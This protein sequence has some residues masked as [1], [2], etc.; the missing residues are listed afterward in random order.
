MSKNFSINK[1]AKD[2][3]VNNNPGI[4]AK[5][6]RN[7]LHA[8]FEKI[9]HGCIVLNENNK[10]IVFGN[11]NDTLKT[12]ATVLS[13]EFYM[14]AGSGG[15][16]GVAEAYAAGYWDAEDMVKLIQIVIKNQ[17]IQEALDGGIA[18]LL[19]PINRLIHSSRK[20]TMS[21]S[22]NNIVAHYDL[23]NDFFKKWLDSSMTYSCAVFEP[24]DISLY[25]ASIEKL[26]RICRK[27]ELKPSDHIIE[28]GTG[29][30]SFAVHA[31]KNYGCSVT[32]TT[33]SEEQFDYVSQLIEKE[34]LSNKITLLKND[35]RDLS[36][37]FDK[38]VSIEMIEAVGYNYIQKFFQVCSNLLKPDGL[39]AFQGITY[40]EQG[41]E[42]HLNSVD[43]IKKY[44]F[45]GSNLIS[46]NHVLSTIKES[47]DL[48]MVH[49]EDITKHYAKTLRLWR[50]KYMSVLPSIKDM[51]FSNE[52]LRIWEYY[53][54]YCEAGFRERFIGDVQ[55]VMAK[56]ENKDIQINY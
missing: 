32:T 21:G 27:L 53:F 19:S 34:N 26:D 30:G 44:I 29:W 52:F 24:K 56:P 14:L 33:I 38:L 11:E 42:D 43:F 28:I 54:I 7:R 40:H 1:A 23:S 10:K 31:V 22:K 8:Q 46:V 12:E 9:K 13:S 3:A 25:D 6:F 5:I 50:E 45:P 41:F 20:N 55:I 48:S 36:G 47:T 4:L 51:G 39:M 15:E 16:V 49:L 35:Y 37:Q 2:T 18:K 17:E